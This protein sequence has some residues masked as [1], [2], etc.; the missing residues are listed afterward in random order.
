MSRRVE[1]RSRIL[2]FGDFRW[3]G[4]EPRE[5]KDPDARWRDVVR[6]VLAGP[7][8]DA[9]FH[10]RYFEV[11]PGGYTT[12]ERHEHEH[13]VVVFRGRGRV[14]LGERWEPLGF[15]DVVYV[16]PNEPHQFRAGDDEP[17]G[18]LCIVSAD[19]DR[20]NPL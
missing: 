13:V 12:F 19:R 8:E 10:V 5:Y 16:A 3:A 9:P 1:R 6:H 7:E 17:F 20:P 4:V 15:G 11:G 2:R 18:F 14:R